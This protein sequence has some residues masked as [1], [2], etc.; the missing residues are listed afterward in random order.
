MVLA[1]GP[2][3]CQEGVGTTDWT[4]GRMAYSADVSEVFRWWRTTDGDYDGAQVEGRAARSSDRRRD[5]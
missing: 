1:Q 3:G 4:P 2:H 5:G